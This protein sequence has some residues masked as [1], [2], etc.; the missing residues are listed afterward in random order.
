MNEKTPGMSF[1]NPTASYVSLVDELKTHNQSI[2]QSQASLANGVRQ[3]SNIKLEKLKK[4][5]N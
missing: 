1:Y 4:N 3:F 5:L 2:K